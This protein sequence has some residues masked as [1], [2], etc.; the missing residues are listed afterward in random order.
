MAGPLRFEL[1][2]API[3]IVAVGAA[4]GFGAVQIGDFLNKQLYID[5]IAASIAFIKQD[6]NMIATWSGN[7]SLGSA[8]TADLTLSGAEVDLIPSTA[9]GPA[10]AGKI[11]APASPVRVSA[12]LATRLWTA[13]E[14]V[15]LNLIVNAAD[16]TD[17]TT[18]VVKAFGY[19]DFFIR[20]L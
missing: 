9:V 14:E 12:S 7:W 2:G 16:I 8:P 18:A 11:A 3:S 19:V 1:L 13:A 5:S 17:S 20:Q 6:S 10:V 15:N 4:I